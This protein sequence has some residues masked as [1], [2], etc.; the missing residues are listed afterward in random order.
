MDRRTVIVSGLA[1]VGVASVARAQSYEP[2]G[3]GRPL[4]GPAPPNQTPNYPVQQPAPPSAPPPPAGA[5][6]YSRD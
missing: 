6:T 1:T 4:D 5:E 3:Q 2:I